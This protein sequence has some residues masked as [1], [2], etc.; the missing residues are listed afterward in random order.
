MLYAAITAALLTALVA[1]VAWGRVPRHWV[2]LAA[3]LLLLATGAVAPSELPGF[4][5]WDVLGL[6]LGMSVFTVF[7]EESGVVELASRAIASRS[8]SPRTL[9]FILALLSGLISV[10]L[11]NVTVVLL[12]APLALRLSRRLGV[13]PVEL[14][15]PIAL[16]S[17][18]AGSATMVGDPPAIMV[19]GFLGLGFADFIWYDGRPSMFFLTLAPMALACGVAA[20]MVRSA[21][22]QPQGPRGDVA[23]DGVRRVDRVFAAEAILS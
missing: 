6:I 5:D 16:A 18:M 11:E 13:D 14:L 3:L 22:A 17:N 15:I 12:L 2:S 23:G 10:F 9:V 21:G 1:L 20:L 19:A 4:I 7:L 8:P